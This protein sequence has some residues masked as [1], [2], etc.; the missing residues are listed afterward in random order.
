MKK[1][2]SNRAAQKIQE[3]HTQQEIDNGI[4]TLKK[5]VSD[6]EHYALLEEKILEEVN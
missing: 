5:V 6:E 4:I 1:L 2:I 3:K